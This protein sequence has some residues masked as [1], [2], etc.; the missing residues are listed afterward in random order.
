MGTT[1]SFALNTGATVKFDFRRAMPGRRVNSRCVAPT[2]RN[3]QKKACTRIVSQGVLSLSGHA[4]TNKIS[5][6]GRLSAA[7]KLPPGTYTLVLT[8]TSASGRSS[9]TSISF[10]IVKG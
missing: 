3:Q 9:P 4:G 7:K 10:T 5:F 2:K 1:F 8:A 6:Q